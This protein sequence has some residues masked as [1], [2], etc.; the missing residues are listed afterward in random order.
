MTNA[1]N[2]GALALV[3]SILVGHLAGGVIGVFALVA[4]GGTTTAEQVAAPAA[5][6]VGVV[7][8]VATFRQLRRRSDSLNE[9]EYCRNP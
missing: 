9:S 2:S 4:L 8:G 7:A 5:L 3:A 1:F 6:I